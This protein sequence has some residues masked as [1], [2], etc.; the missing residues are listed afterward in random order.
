MNSI[1]EGSQSSFL[2]I[3]MTVTVEMKHYLEETRSYNPIGVSALA[4]SGEKI[5]SC[6]G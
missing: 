4:F 3:Y 2:L 1:N 6:K 5:A